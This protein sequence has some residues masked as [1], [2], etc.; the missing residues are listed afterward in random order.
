[1]EDLNKYNYISFK[2]EYKCNKHLILNPAC[3]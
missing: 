3:M 1:M 2:N